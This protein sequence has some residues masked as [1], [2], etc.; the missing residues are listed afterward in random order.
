MSQSRSNQRNSSGFSQRN[1]SGFSQRNS[2]GFS[3]RNSSEYSFY[4]CTQ[5]SIDP[6]TKGLFK[7][8]ILDTIDE[9]EHKCTC[10]KRD[11]MYVQDYGKCEYTCVHDIEEHQWTNK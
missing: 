5:D 11:Y 6:A 1:S 7:P 10:G 3:Q 8:G 2:S 4:A 9:E